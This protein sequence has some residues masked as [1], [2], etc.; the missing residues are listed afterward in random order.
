MEKPLI[1]YTIVERERDG[2]K[3][4]VRIGSAFRQKDG[5]INVH[6][7]A[8]PVNGTL[9]I[10]EASPYRSDPEAEKPPVIEP[11]EGQ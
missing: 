11:V 4:W 8:I 6:L 2:K 9:C 5:S 1:A 7:D 10:R 3:F